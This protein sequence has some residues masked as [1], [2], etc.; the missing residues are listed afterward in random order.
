MLSKLANL[1]WPG[2]LVVLGLIAGIVCA[3]I[4]APPEYMQWIAGGGAGS[5]LIAW[6]IQTHRK[7]EEPSE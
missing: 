4:F 6:W 2:A 5:T 7:P 3:I 1:N